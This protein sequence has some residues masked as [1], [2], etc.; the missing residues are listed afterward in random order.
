MATHVFKSNAAPF[1]HE[2][3]Y[4][5]IEDDFLVHVDGTYSKGLTLSGLDTWTLANNR[6][7]EIYNHLQGLVGSLPE[8]IIFQFLVM[9]DENIEKDLK[10]FFEKFNVC[11]EMQESILKD[12]KQVLESSLSRRY[13]LFLFISKRYQPTRKTLFQNIVGFFKRSDSKKDDSFEKQVK[14]A[15]QEL[16]RAC[17]TIISYL[18]QPHLQIS[19]KPMNEKELVDLLYETVNPRKN[20][21]KPVS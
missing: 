16:T 4:W 5:A 6:L 14:R 13:R 9:S 7:N 11:S 12:R 18:H 19:I 10:L 8:D 1:A 21:Y 15:F 2:L 20:S 3:P 17:S